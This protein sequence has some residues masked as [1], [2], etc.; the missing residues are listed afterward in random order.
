MRLTESPCSTSPPGAPE[1]DADGTSK[2]SVPTDSGGIDESGGSVNGTGT[3]PAATRAATN[4]PATPPTSFPI[5]VSRPAEL[6][7]GPRPP[8]KTLTG[9]GSGIEQSTM[10][11]TPAVTMSAITPTVFWKSSVQ[12]RL[13]CAFPDVLTQ[14][15]R[16][17]SLT[18]S[19]VGLLGVVSVNDWS[20]PA[21]SH[22]IGRTGEPLAPSTCT[23]AAAP[24]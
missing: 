5:S 13:I 20:E 21:L 17:E 22:S 7:T 1:I 15:S 6:K 8:E 11:Q 2:P 16:G 19:G 10:R 9:D 3:N 12:W 14:W 4:G 24:P 23:S 18:P